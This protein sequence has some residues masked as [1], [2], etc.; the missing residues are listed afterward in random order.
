MENF[1]P[2]SR[3]TRM[4]RALLSLRGLSIGDAFGDRFF[5]PHLRVE[6]RPIPRGPWHYTDDTEMAIALVEVLHHHDGIDQ[7]DLAETF[8]RRFNKEPN[9]GYGAGAH[10]LLRGITDGLPWITQSRA[11]FGGRGSLGNGSAMRVAP[12][13]A[14]FAD[15]LPQLVVEATRS[16]EVTHAHPEGIAGAVAIAAA[17]AFAWNNRVQKIDPT[18]FFDFVLDATPSGETRDAI[19]K[20]K[21]LPLTYDVRTAAHA[22]GNG[23]RITVPD[24]VPF[25]VWC[26]AR[27]LDS[28][29]EAIWTAIASG[30]DIDTMAAIVGGI[31]VLSAPEATL[32]AAWVQEREPLRFEKAG[33]QA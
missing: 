8:A 11:M 32:P 29:E 25:A 5:S 17:A 15:D 6:E 4:Q 21:H 24:T 27:H 19:A 1:M 10:Q 14:Y 9:R 23:I 22:L 3:T 13:G 2:D 26:A 20:A 18:A 28:Y 16:A 7:D 12:L 33:L 30:G 31:V